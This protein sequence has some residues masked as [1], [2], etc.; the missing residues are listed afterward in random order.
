MALNIG[1]ANKA[2]VGYFLQNSLK[3][4]QLSMDRSFNRYFLLIKKN[5]FAFKQRLVQEKSYTQL[6]KEAD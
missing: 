5:Q 4:H 2:S 1:S 6:F 3:M